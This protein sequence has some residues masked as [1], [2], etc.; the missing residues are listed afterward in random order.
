MLGLGIASFVEGG[1]VS[2]SIASFINSKSLDFDG[3][4][5]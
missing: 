4:N 2:K 3:S 5:D 1:S